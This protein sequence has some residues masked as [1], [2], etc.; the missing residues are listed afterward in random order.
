MG[1]L[2]GAYHHQVLL[3]L[4]I[5]RFWHKMMLNKLHQCVIRLVSDRW[6]SCCHGHQ[7]LVLLRVF[8]T[9]PL[10]K[11]PLRDRRMALTVFL[12]KQRM[13]LEV[14]LRDRRMLLTWLCSLPTAY[15]SARQ[16]QH[17]LLL[18]LRRHG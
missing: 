6:H 8:K 17:S 14:S 4:Q 15:R 5:S 11:A 3:P 13:V 16:L 9:A 2:E 10:K 12:R 1:A 7:W 18:L